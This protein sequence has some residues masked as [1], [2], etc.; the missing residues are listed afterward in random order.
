MVREY[1]AFTHETDP[2]GEHD[3]G[4]F[5]FHGITIYLRIVCFAAEFGQSKPDPADPIQARRLLSVSMEDVW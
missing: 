2:L 4:K 5:Q 3:F 1:D